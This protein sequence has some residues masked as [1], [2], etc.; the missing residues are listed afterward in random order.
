[1]PWYR[2]HGKRE[3]PLSP[4]EF[5]SALE[6]AKFAKPSHKAFLILLYYTGVR[7]GELVRVMREQFWVKD[8]CLY[9]DVGKRLKGGMHTPP[10]VIPLSAP[11]MMEVWQF[12]EKVKHGKRV[13][14]FT[15]RTAYNI[16][17]RALG[18][19]PHH[20]RLNRITDFLMK[21]FSIP[22]V[23][24]WSGHASTKSLDSYI[25]IVSVKKLGEALARRER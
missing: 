4:E 14:P 5:F 8:G 11:Y 25:G 13:F 3:T 16:V 22:E 12:I 15:P 18:T 21:G 20:L 19:Y 23:K 9:F 17:C 24:S 2:R 6:K 1:M 7:K 10:L